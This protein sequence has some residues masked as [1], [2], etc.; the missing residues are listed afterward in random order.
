MSRSVVVAGIGFVVLLGVALVFSGTGRHRGHLAIG[1]D[2]KVS[3]VSVDAV[4]PLLVLEPVEAETPRTVVQ[5]SR[6]DLRVN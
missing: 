5:Q 2:V 6:V 3:E 1:T 4:G